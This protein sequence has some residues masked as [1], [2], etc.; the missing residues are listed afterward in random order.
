MNASDQSCDSEDE[1]VALIAAHILATPS[2]RVYI[3]P[4]NTFDATRQ[5]LSW[6]VRELAWATH[7]PGRKGT[8]SEYAARVC[9][10]AAERAIVAHAVSNQAEWNAQMV[11]PRRLFLS[12]FS[13]LAPSAPLAA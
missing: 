10:A 11:M 4:G 8:A 2:L 13:R 12:D 7:V 9:D 5:C 6:L 1:V 3:N